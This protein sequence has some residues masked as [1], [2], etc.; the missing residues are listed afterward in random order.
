M[1]RCQT[2]CKRD[3]KDEKTLAV[4]IT[5]LLGP[6]KKL[7]G[8]PANGDPVHDAQDYCIDPCFVEPEANCLASTSTVA[9]TIH[10]NV[11]QEV[12]PEKEKWVAKSIVCSRFSNDDSLQRTGNI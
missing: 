7:S 10:S 11:F 9:L 2:Y 5:L 8:N 6:M 12:Q 4:N 3:G 1:E